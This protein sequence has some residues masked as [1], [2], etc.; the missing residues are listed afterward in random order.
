MDY[1]PVILHNASLR[2]DR[3][4]EIEIAGILLLMLEV[5]HVNVL[6]MTLTKNLLC[7]Q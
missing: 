6:F 5:K 3:D 4:T 2:I 7:F 1:H